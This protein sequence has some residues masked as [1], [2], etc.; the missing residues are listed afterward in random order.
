MTK[1]TRLLAIHALLGATLATG[2]FSERSTEPED[3]TPCDGTT[4]ACVVNVT[5]NTFSPRNLLV[6]AGSTVRWVNNGASPHTSTGDGW[7]SGTM[8]VGADFE[9]T[10]DEAGDFDYVCDFHPGMS[11]TIRGE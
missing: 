6:E 11:G 1:T 5:D 7:D 3:T 9:H 8:L 10:F 4:T 2:C